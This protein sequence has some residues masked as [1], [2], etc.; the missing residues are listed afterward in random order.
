[1]RILLLTQVVPYP[2]T[3]GPKIK[4]YNVLRFLARR[5][6][7]HLL[8]FVRS[9]EEQRA[10]EALGEYCASISTV[11]LQRSAARDVGFLLQSLLHG[12]SFLIERDWNP[13]LADRVRHLVRR[14]AIEA[15]HADQLSMAQYAVDAPVPLR[16]LDQHNAVWTIVRRAARV[17]RSL[18]RRLLAELE[19]RRLRAYEGAVC[20]RFDQVTVV[21]RADRDALEQ[22]A[23]E[24]IPARV[25]PIAVDTDEYAYQPRGAGARD[26]LSLATMFYPPN[27]EGVC[28]F[29]RDVLP[30]L[31][32]GFPEARLLVVGSRP[33]TSVKRL[34]ASDSGVVVTGFVPDLTPILER[35]A[36][37][38]VPLRSGS[39]MRVKILEA[40]ARGI[41]VVSTSI[42]VEG[43]E[44]I[45]GEHLLVADSPADFA[46]A[47]AALLRGP[48]RAA[49]LAQAARELAESRY[50]WR[51]ALHG[52]DE[53]YGRSESG[54]GPALAPLPRVLARGF[55]P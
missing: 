19:W 20:R 33:P 26:L 52:L 45:P 34:G 44:A 31:R 30:L 25:I 36:L 6:Q 28:W 8:S 15:I 14:H 12:R 4:T 7:V 5:H 32:V 2:P 48:R 29:A 11:R 51:L 1:M 53:L 41:P 16:V 55:A 54:H 37:M 50:D 43:I 27:V 39:G 17:E 21:S 42:G 46:A 22:A 9:D 10:A 24:P 3:S 49:R 13:A 18:P 35:S 40:F 47:V 38:V 23:G